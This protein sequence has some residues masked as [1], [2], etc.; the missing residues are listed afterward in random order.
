[1][2]SEIAHPVKCPPLSPQAALLSEC[3]LPACCACGSLCWQKKTTI[4]N[5]GDVNNAH[6]NECQMPGFCPVIDD[7]TIGRAACREL[8]AADKQ[9]N[10]VAVTEELRSG[11]LGCSVDSANKYY[12]NSRDTG[13]QQTTGSA[14]VT[15][16]AN[17][18]QIIC[19]TADFTVSG[20]AGT[21]STTRD[22]NTYTFS[23]SN[24]NGQPA[25]QT[26][27]CTPF[28]PSP[29]PPSPGPPPSPPPSPSPFPPP[30][31]SPS[32]TPP[33]TPV[34]TTFDPTILIAVLIPV[35]L[36]CCMLS[37]CCYYWY[38]IVP[39]RKRAW[40]HVKLSK[41][42]SEMLAL[43]MLMDR[44]NSGELDVAELQSL[45]AWLHDNV[46]GGDSGWLT[47]M[48]EALG[49]VTEQ[50]RTSIIDKG[51]GA[52]P[53]VGSK[54]SKTTGTETGEIKVEAIALPPVSPQSTRRKSEWRV[55]PC[56]PGA[57]VRDDD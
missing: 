21:A 9:A 3:H 20:P 2:S 39:K 52:R 28:P 19:V 48:W 12:F 22:G 18:R 47:V 5:I 15:D 26:A 6:Y 4:Y 30:P 56:V 41:F 53:V 37:L 14:W 13:A 38:Y 50:T 23:N 25:A 31:M 57:R 43:F 45:L 42:E 33:P 1:M 7:P 24:E 8:A 36:L 44:D 11:P 32:P 10:G 46:P 49:E 16:T 35:L 40:K 34:I 27:L 55:S 17:T 29:P 51:D 54:A